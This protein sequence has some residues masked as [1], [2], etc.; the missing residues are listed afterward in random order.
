MNRKQKRAYVAKTK[1]AQTT[2]KLQSRVKSLDFNR[3]LIAQLLAKL[4]HEQGSFQGDS[5]VAQL[6][7]TKEDLL[8]PYNLGVERLDNE[9]GR[10]RGIR[11]TCEKQDKTNEAE[12]DFFTRLRIQ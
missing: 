4:T 8:V 9:A 2:N 5:G 3:K 12:V 7:F 10:L 6:E 1:K 11:L